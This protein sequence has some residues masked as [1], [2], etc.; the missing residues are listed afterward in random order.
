MPTGLIG[1]SILFPGTLSV[2]LFGMLG[3]MLADRRGHI[4]AGFLVVFFYT[5]RTPWHI[6][7]T[8]ILTFGGLSFVKTVISAS[9]A[10]ALKPD[11]AGSGIACLIL[12][13]SCPKVSALPG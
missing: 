1:S 4:I 13:A 3:G 6:A 7:G 8:M 9:A 2:I 11:E 5:D 10:K 12:S